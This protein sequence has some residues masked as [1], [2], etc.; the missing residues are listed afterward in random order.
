[1]NLERLQELAASLRRETGT[2]GG[3]DEAAAES[4]VRLETR[5][6]AVRRRVKLHHASLI[7]ETADRVLPIRT[8]EELQIVVD[9]TLEILVQLVERAQQLGHVPQVHGQGVEALVF[10][11]A[12]RRRGGEAVELSSAIRSAAVRRLE[13]YLRSLLKGF[14]RDEV[15]PLGVGEDDLRQE[16]MLRLLTRD[17]LP[18]LN[19]GYLK[20]AYGN[21][22]ADS[23]RRARSR[24]SEESLDGL[25]RNEQGPTGFEPAAPRWSTDP[26]LL[27]EGQSELDGVLTALNRL[28]ARRREALLLTA[29]GHPSHE[30]AVRMG[31]TPEAVRQLV[32]RGRRE[33]RQILAVPHS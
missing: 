3:A 26:A 10:I 5:L 20:R 18:N 2:A 33:L 9:R 31:T 19:R 4:R 22:V 13:T 30:V 6:E 24:P 15:G 17:E 25:L 23:H 27:L 29:E 12:A 16:I 11:A 14:V 8:P 1:M 21:L 32:F 7:A 28:D